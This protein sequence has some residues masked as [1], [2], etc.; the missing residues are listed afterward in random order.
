MEF[1][2]ARIVML[3]FTIEKGLRNNMQNDWEIDREA[4]RDNE[5]EIEVSLNGISYKV[6]Q[7]TALL[8]HCLFLI[9]DDLQKVKSA[10][11]DLTRHL[12]KND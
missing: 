12:E 3:K 11:Y 10:I 2:F 4:Y 1:V 7:D 8:S 5:K 6:S 9:S